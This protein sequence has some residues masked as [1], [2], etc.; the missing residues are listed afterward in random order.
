LFK[1]VL[2]LGAAIG[3]TSFSENLLTSVTI[4]ANVKRS[5]GP[6]PGDL[7]DIY[8]Q[9]RCRAESNTFR[10]GAKHGESCERVLAV[11]RQLLPEFCVPRKATASSERREVSSK[12]PRC[13]AI[14]GICGQ[15]PEIYF[16]HHL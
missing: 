16:Y 8:T 7:A 2:N 9:N 1:R 11:S 10:D 3:K 4:G 5:E 12:L 15:W 14:T 13:A 6:F